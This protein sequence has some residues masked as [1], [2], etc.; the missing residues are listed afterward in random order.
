VDD[1]FL[2]AYQAA[3]VAGYTWE[4]IDSYMFP[5]EPSP[6][7]KIAQHNLSDILLRTGT[8]ATPPCK[9]VAAQLKE[10]TDF[11][12]ANK[13]IVHRLWLNIEQTDDTCFSWKM[14]STVKNLQ[15]ANNWIG[16]IS[17]DSRK[18]P[19]RKWGIFAPNNVYVR[20]SPKDKFSAF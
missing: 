3:L 14:G 15:L 13:I 8:N 1:Y 11:L 7:F 2:D 6:I 19:E 18:N 12:D 5:C 17:E 16:A 4:Q 20:V 9:S 10:F